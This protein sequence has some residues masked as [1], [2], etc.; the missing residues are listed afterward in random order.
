MVPLKEKQA[1]LEKIA[2]GS[3][4]FGFSVDES[5]VYTFHVV[6]LDMETNEK[7]E[8]KATKMSL[9]NFSDIFGPNVIYEERNAFY[10]NDD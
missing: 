7:L 5:D 1:L 6:P 4:T 10:K 3:Y 8:D 9:G 2:T